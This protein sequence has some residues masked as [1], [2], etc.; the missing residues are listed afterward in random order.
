MKCASWHQP[1]EY[2]AFACCWGACLRH[3]RERQQVG[4]RFLCATALRHVHVS[5]KKAAA[6]AAMRSWTG[7]VPICAALLLQ[8]AQADATFRSAVLSC[9]EGDDSKCKTAASFTAAVSNWDRTM[10]LSIGSETGHALLDCKKAHHK[11]QSHHSLHSYIW[12]RSSGELLQ[13]QLN[14]SY[15]FAETVAI[16]AY[17]LSSPFAGAPAYALPFAG[18]APFQALPQTDC[19]FVLRRSVL[20][21]F[22]GVLQQCV[23]AILRGQ[24][25]R[26]R[27]LRSD[28]HHA[29]ACN[30]HI[31]DL[32]CFHH[33][34]GDPSTGLGSQCHSKRLVCAAASLGSG[35][36]SCSAWRARKRA[37]EP[38]SASAGLVNDA[39]LCRRS[40]APF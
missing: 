31:A 23:R 4:P 11:E 20:A 14:T 28:R 7:L 35:A 32:C 1:P 24:R 8:V 16:T 27:F 5:Q 19:F 34:P 25:S 2:I 9:V 15:Y 3:V 36:C 30:G 38:A 40:G 13:D 33:H 26:R 10:S 29:L 22:C 6:E 21:D 12:L 18:S 37:V 39:P 17:A